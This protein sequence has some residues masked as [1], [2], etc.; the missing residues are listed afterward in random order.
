MS[1]LVGVKFRS[2]GL[3]YVSFQ[4]SAVIDGKRLNRS[5]YTE[6]VHKLSKGRQTNV[7]VRSRGLI[8]VQLALSMEQRLQ[9][10]HV[11]S[12]FLPPNGAAIVR[13]LGSYG[14]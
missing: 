5:T 6:R 11:D 9:G 13:V 10:L 1:H 7:K 12:Q 8:C 3:L 14:L 2:Y 4:S